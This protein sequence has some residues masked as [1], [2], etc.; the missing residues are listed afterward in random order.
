MV[1]EFW[2]NKHTIDLTHTDQIQNC[3]DLKDIMEQINTPLT[4]V[5]ETLESI[6]DNLQGKLFPVLQYRY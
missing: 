3:T 1:C 6:Q 4:R 2:S 5:N